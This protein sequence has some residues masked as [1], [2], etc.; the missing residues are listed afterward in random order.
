MSPQ[1]V[2][3]TL[4]E[5]QRRAVWQAA[6]DTR[7]EVTARGTPGH[8]APN[9]DRMLND[10]RAYGAEVAASVVR[11]VPWNGARLSKR[12]AGDLRDGSEVRSTPY[13]HGR[14]LICHA[15]H[16]ERPYIL[17]TGRAPTYTVRGWMRGREARCEEYWWPNAPQ[18]PCWAVPQSALLDIRTLGTVING[19]LV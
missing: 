7:D 14:L 1:S 18:R 5:E 13:L 9:G 15:D 6:R 11:C 2:R 8:F 17:V 10:V 19:V 4:T 3:V 16:D 12:Y